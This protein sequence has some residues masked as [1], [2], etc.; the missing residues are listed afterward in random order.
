[1]M[2]VKKQTSRFRGLTKRTSKTHG[3]IAVAALIAVFVVVGVSVK[4]FSHAASGGY[5]HTFCGGNGAGCLNAWNGGPWVNSYGNAH[6][7]NDDF[8]SV[9]LTDGASTYIMD[10]GANAWSGNCIGDA[11]NKSGDSQASL[12]P[13]PGSSK[14]AGWGTSFQVVRGKK[15]TGN[16]VAFLNK[17]WND[18]LGPAN[19]IGFANGSHFT[20][21]GGI[22]CFEIGPAV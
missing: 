20:L 11:Y 19:G 18:F 16:T 6:V 12:D 3:L 9:N 15:C 2:P 21:D 13:C 4:T 14:G 17:R 22:Y 10:S 5:G 1:M 8:Y 7:G